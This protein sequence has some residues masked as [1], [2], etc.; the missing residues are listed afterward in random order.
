MDRQIDNNFIRL[1]I[2][3]GFNYCNMNANSVEK[4]TFVVLNKK[5][6]SKS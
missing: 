1:S 2:E 4:P 6:T 3:W 5:I